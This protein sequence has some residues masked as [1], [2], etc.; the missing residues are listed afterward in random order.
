MADNARRA[1]LTVEDAK[2][3]ASAVYPAGERLYE[4]LSRM[5]E[6]GFEAFLPRSRFIES[7]CPSRE[8]LDTHRRYRVETAKELLGFLLP[9]S[10]DRA[11]RSPFIR[12]LRTQRDQSNGVPESELADRYSREEGAW[13]IEIDPCERNRMIALV[14][15]RPANEARWSAVLEAEL[16][17]M[18]IEAQRDA[19]EFSKRYGFDR[20][21]RYA[22]YTAVMERETVPLGFAF[23]ARGSCPDY[24]V[25]S[26]AINEN[27]ELRL[28]LE[29]PRFFYWNPGEGNIHTLYLAVCARGLKSKLATAK[30][31]TVLFI[32][33]DKVLYG[34]R[35]FFS[36]AELERVVTARVHWYGLMAPDI[37][38]G[39]GSFFKGGAR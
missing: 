10:L 8:E 23:N 29:E 31:G 14:A 30:K 3:I 5:Q 32:D 18:Q 27:W 28:T 12:E 39:V 13:R 21:G 15:D 37:E 16:R 36:Q 17:Q 11:Y 6:A 2:A 7:F 20:E 24:P 26:K 33:Y 25:F 4:H 1:P 19:S 38:R 35:S 9:L 22:L 34:Y